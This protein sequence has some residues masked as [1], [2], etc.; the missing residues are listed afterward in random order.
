MAP[1][2]KPPRKQQYCC[3]D[4]KYADELK[5]FFHE[6]YS[7]CKWNMFENDQKAEA[8]IVCIWEMLN[9]R[10][11]RLEEQLEPNTVKNQ[12]EKSLIEN[13]LNTG[14]C[15]SDIRGSKKRK[16]RSRTRC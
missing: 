14:E 5:L 10:L 11:D 8:T 15:A 2:V 16:P 6:R 4:I 7:H 1:K 3:D 13:L 12:C 9:R